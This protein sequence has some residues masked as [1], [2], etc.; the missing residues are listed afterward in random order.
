MTPVTTV[1]LRE[2]RNNY[3]PLI[4]RVRAGELVT[5]S[6]D[7]VPA[8]DLVPHVPATRPPRFRSTRLDVVWAPLSAGEAHA[9]RL[10]VRDR[11]GETVE[12][13]RDPWE[14]G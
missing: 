7:G 8:V 6:V 10:E 12:Q 11:L 4:E 1:P 2:L 9:W 3:G 14:S 13:L 5:V